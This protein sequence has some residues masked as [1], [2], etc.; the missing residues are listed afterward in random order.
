M[1]MQKGKKIR[2]LEGIRQGK[3][4]GGETYLL[5]LV[6]RL[7]RSRFEPVVLSFTEG[8]MV[9]KLRSL[10]ISTH[11]IHTEKPFDFF[12]WRKVRDFIREQEIDI[13]HAHGTRANSNLFWA[14][15]KLKIPIMYTC[16]GWSFHPNQNAA[17][18][19][20]RIWSEG[21]LTSR[22][23]VNVCVSKANRD[24]G[25]KL[26]RNFDALVSNNS[27]DPEKFNPC[28][29]YKNVRLELG[30]SATAIVVV[31]VARFTLQKQPLKLISAFAGVCKKIKDVKLLMVGDGEQREKAVELLRHLGL[32][33]QVILQ[34]FRQDVPDLLAA[35]DI[36]VLPSLWEG[37]PIALM[38]AMSMGKAVIGTA[39][40]GTPEIIE[41]GENGLLIGTGDMEK[42][43]EEAIIRLCED[44]AF[45]ARLQQNA[46]KSI[47]SKY[48]VETLARQNEEVYRLLA[49]TDEE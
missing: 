45:R 35:S 34:P 37:F 46:I 20:F 1:R 5:G 13:V 6:E 19:K 32:E 39:V 27:I 33:D 47:Y 7:D 26:F 3:I 44:G 38:E 9:D 16:H 28:K 40:D 12:I 14:A 30:I 10:G 49:G 11:V 4:G 17:V 18:R 25:R 23:N 24:M 2:V 31:S 29:N 8:P 36:F 42:N 43:L 21:F 41:D 48:N 22:M 15:G